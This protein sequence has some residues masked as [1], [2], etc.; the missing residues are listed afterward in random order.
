MP[1]IIP[2]GT[3][4]YPNAKV[5]WHAIYETGLL[6]S[7]TYAMKSEHGA[8][9][10]CKR[11]GGSVEAS[12]PL[13]VCSPSPHRRR[14]GPAVSYLLFTKLVISSSSNNG[15][16][17][18]LFTLKSSLPLGWSLVMAQLGCP[19]LHR[20]YK[21]GRRWTAAYNMHRAG[22]QAECCPRV[23]CGCMKIAVALLQMRLLHVQAIHSFRISGRH[24]NP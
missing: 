2:V 9:N 1:Q 5:S 16:K 13:V 7:N 10:F 8:V 21:A 17:D 20:T 14:H 12:A 23:E 15:N 19:A 18:S 4:G 11:Q 22:Q 3:V 6:K 24:L